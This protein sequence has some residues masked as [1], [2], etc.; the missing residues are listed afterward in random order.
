M[1]WKHGIIFLA[2]IVFLIIL[3]CAV[4]L[5]ANKASGQSSAG[6]SPTSQPYQRPLNSGDLP[7]IGAAIQVQRVDWMDRYK[8][9]MDEIAAVGGDTVLLAVDMRQEDGSSSE[10][11]LDMRRTPTPDQMI[12]LI[13]HAKSQHLRVILM[14]IVLLNHPRDATEWRGT[15][16]PLYWDHWW[17]TYRE[18]MLQFAWIAEAGGADVL[19]VGSELVSTESKVD[20]WTQTITAIRSRYSG[21]LTYSANWDRYNTIHF[22]DQLDL[23]AMNSYWTLGDSS[24][25]T[26]EQIQAKWKPI[27]AD[28]LAFQQKEH[29]PLLFMEVGWCSLSNAAEAPWDY[30]QSSVKI[31]LPLQK[32]LYEAFFNTWWGQPRLGG[33]MVWEWPPGDGGPEDRGYTPENK[34]AEQVLRQW[35]A[36]PRWQVIE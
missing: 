27:Q 35:L 21:R 15:L 10:I 20:Q 31:N 16:K 30:T 14:P 18:A 17:D 32:R 13:K 8:K 34:P 1:F 28:L 2:A 3:G 4:T 12:D 11:F 5:P 36:K 24:N 23:I 6:G 19:S 25:V 29:K 22:W 9:C 26:V 33:F 7:Y